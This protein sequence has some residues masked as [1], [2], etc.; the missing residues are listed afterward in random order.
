MAFFLGPLVDPLLVLVLP[1]LSL[2][3]L[4]A[5][6]VVQLGHFVGILEEVLFEVSQFL[7]NHG[8]TLILIHFS[9][10]S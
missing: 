2:A 3:H 4:E 6:V 7:L 10:C 9:H 8:S 1:R 5:L